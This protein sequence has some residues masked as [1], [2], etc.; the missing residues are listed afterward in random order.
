MKVAQDINV[1]NVTIIINPKTN[2]LEAK[3]PETSGSV[4]IEEVPNV[5]ASNYIVTLDGTQRR[6]TK[7]GKVSGTE[8]LV[9]QL[10][11]PPPPKPYI[12]K[13]IRIEFYDDVGVDS[14]NGYEFTHTG[15]VRVI[16]KDGSPFTP[17]G[18]S[19]YEGYMDSD[20]RL[21]MSGNTEINGDG[22]VTINFNTM[23][24]Q[25]DV[26]YGDI[27]TSS[28]L[29]SAIVLSTNGFEVEHEDAFYRYYITSVSRGTDTPAQPEPTNIET[30]LDYNCPYMSAENNSFT[31][32]SPMQI[33]IRT[34]D[35][36]NKTPQ[37]VKF[38]VVMNH[39][40]RTYSYPYSSSNVYE[41]NSISDFN[42]GADFYIINNL[43]IENVRVEFTD[44]SSSIPKMSDRWC[45][46]GSQPE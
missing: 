36:G 29:T 25:A 13:N 39:L 1:D 42:E 20:L 26:S 41:W 24:Y 38:D 19:A 45:H 4:T 37:T 21:T 35:V 28:T 32:V 18:S 3:L 10:D 27:Q 17:N 34:S 44:G 14:G 11:N 22:Y 7:L 12:E 23:T 30:F 40:T 5:S 46:V 6:I 43:K 15:K 31:M 9:F 8:W 33:T 2:Q 16:T